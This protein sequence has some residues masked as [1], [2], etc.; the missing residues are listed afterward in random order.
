METQKSLKEIQQNKAQE[1]EANKEETQKRLKE[2]QE[3][4]S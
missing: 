2:M 1:I 3:K 4:V